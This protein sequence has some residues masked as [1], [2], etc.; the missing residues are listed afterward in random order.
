MGVRVIACAIGGGAESHDAFLNVLLAWT[1]AFGTATLADLDSV[2]VRHWWLHRK[3]SEHNQ[4]S[5]HLRR[6]KRAN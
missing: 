6:A 4:L 2:L 1:T 5:D 3:T